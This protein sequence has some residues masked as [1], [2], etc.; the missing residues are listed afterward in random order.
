MNKWFFEYLGIYPPLLQNLSKSARK[1]CEWS[2]KAEMN[3]LVNIN[4]C[5]PKLGCS[6]SELPA[7]NKQRHGCINV[8]SK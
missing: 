1:N 4:D 3:I 6:D 2:L 5:R 7:E 8:K